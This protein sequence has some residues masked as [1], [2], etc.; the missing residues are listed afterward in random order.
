MKSKKGVSPVITTVLLVLI[1]LTLASLIIVW[2]V[3]FIP[4]AIAKFDSPIE[5]ACQNVDFTAQ[6]VSD[7]TISIVNVG[8]VY[9]YKIGVKEVGGPRSQIKENAVELTSGETYSALNI[10]ISSGQVS[11]IPIILGLTESGE[12]QEYSCEEANWKT[13]TM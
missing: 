6:K 4:E 8:N 2:G 10:G 3:T 13:V 5:N 12:Y 11:V 9:I 7:S 1:V